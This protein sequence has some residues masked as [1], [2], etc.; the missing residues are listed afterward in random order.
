MKWQHPPAQSGRWWVERLRFSGSVRTGLWR[1]P[2]WGGSGGLCLLG[3]L[4]GVLEMLV[5]QEC[6]EK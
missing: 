5:G 2:R 3:G 6:P 1:A 4:R